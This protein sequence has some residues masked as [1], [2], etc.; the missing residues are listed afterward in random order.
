MKY[1]RWLIAGIRF[2]CGAGMF[3]AFGG[4]M[5]QVSGQALDQARATMF[6]PF[7]FKV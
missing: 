1:L 2:R 7:G 5:V 4:F 3:L 6:V